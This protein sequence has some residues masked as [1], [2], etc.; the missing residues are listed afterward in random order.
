MA[1]RSFL[2]L[3]LLAAAWVP[4]RGESPA[5]T[6]ILRTGV[7]HGNEVQAES[8]E[9]WFGLVRNEDGLRLVGAPI[10]VTA[11]NDAVMDED[12]DERSGR[13]VR[14]DLE[15]DP[16]VLLAGSD[17]SDRPVPT[18]DYEWNW[19]APAEPLQV[20]FAGKSYEV[21]AEWDGDGQPFG[22][23]PLT[24]FRLRLQTEGRTQDLV[25]PEWCCDEAFP[26]VVWAGDLDQDGALDL[27]VEA[28]YHY[29][30]ST[31][32]L[33]LSTAAVEGDLMGKVATFTSTGC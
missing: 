26:R 13:E 33:F 32:V 11:V 19:E 17:W 24:N 8:G 16:I 22:S 28:S 27:L 14:V 31:Y 7:F 30:V 3:I 18:V 29:N 10:Q 5:G 2:I 4:V 20:T 9:R 23:K 12:P 21:L 1:S 25:T 15:E 6:R